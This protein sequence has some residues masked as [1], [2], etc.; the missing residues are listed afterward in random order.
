MF[1]QLFFGGVGTG[2]TNC[3]TLCYAYPSDAIF[4][5]KRY[6]GSDVHWWIVVGIIEDY[7]SPTVESVC[8]T[9]TIK[10]MD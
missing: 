3:Q 6:V 2:N 5:R 4:F 7:E 8:N 1:V 9:R 10:Y